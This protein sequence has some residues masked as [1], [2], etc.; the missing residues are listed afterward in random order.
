MMEG[1]YTGSIWIILDY[2]TFSCMVGLKYQNES[3]LYLNLINVNYIYLF[4]DRGRVK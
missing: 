1:H 2:K 3:R 4:Q